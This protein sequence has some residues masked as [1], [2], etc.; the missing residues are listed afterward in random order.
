M[1]IIQDLNYPARRM[2]SIPVNWIGGMPVHLKA[3]LRFHSYALICMHN[4]CAVVFDERFN[5]KKYSHTG[6]P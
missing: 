4:Y 1:R 6:N 3:I 5:T 2:E